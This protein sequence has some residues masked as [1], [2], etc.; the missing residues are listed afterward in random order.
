[1]YHSRDEDSEIGMGSCVYVAY[2]FHWRGQSL[3]LPY[4]PQ[5]R[6]WHVVLNTLESSPLPLDEKKEKEAEVKFIEVPGRT[7][8]V[9]EG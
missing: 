9:L 7:V 3:A 1:M 5:G 8:I 4:L 6:Q 2:N